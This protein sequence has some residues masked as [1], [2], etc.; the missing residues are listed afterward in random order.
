MALRKQK[1]TN[2]LHILCR[3]TCQHLLCN[4]RALVL[5]AGHK[6]LCFAILNFNSLD[7]HLVVHPLNLHLVVHSSVSVNAFSMQ[8]ASQVLDRQQ[9]MLI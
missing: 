1:C 6:H 5:L 9:G 4:T 3:K 2:L 8:P 7:R